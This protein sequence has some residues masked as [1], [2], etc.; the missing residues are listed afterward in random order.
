M[1]KTI[2]PKHI[3][4]VIR[5]MVQSGSSNSEIAIAIGTTERRLQAR[6]SQLG[7][8]RERNAR[9]RNSLPIRVPTKVVKGYME[10]AHHRNIEPQN[11]MRLVLARVAEDNLFAA[12][13]DDGK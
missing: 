4:D 6:M 7:L 11:L 2:Y 3:V 8:T 1:P 10:A 5:R 12:L 13:L 9:L